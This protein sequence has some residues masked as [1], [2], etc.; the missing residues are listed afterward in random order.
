MIPFLWIVVCLCDLWQILILIHTLGSDFLVLDE[1]DHIRFLKPE[2]GKVN[3]T[4]HSS[5]E[6]IDEVR[7]APEA[8]Q[9]ME[10]TFETVVVKIQGQKVVHI[11]KLLNVCEK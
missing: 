2:P 10:S 8:G 6:G 3:V 1:A 7:R 9:I 5:Q 11:E 4:I